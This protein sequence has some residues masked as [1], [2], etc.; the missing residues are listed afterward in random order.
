MIS[1]LFFFLTSMRTDIFCFGRF[2]SPACADGL[3]RDLFDTTMVC[4][5]LKLKLRG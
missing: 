3:F 1:F 2:D 4:M 5:R